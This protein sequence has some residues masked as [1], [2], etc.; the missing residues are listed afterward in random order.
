M[1]YRHKQLRARA[2]LTVVLC[3]DQAEEYIQKLLAEK[4]AG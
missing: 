2:V 3:A 4:E 1:S